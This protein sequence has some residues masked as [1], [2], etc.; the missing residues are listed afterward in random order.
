M[1]APVAVVLFL[2][3]LHAR[4]T[5]PAE[6]EKENKGQAD[7]SKRGLLP[8]LLGGSPG[9]GQSGIGGLLG[10]SPSHGY[11]G[12]PQSIGSGLVD[13]VTGLLPLG[14]QSPGGSLNDL[15]NGV[16]KYDQ[17]ATTA[18]P[19]PP[20][21]RGDAPWSQSERTYRQ[22]IT[23][24]GHTQGQR[25]IVLLVPPTGGNGQ[26]VWPRSPY[27]QLPRYG[28]SIC[29]VDNLSKSTGDA[30][31]TAE[32][33]AYAIIHLAAQSRQP[34]NVISYSQGGM[35]AQWAFTFWPS[36]RRLVTNFIALASPFHGT[37]AANVVC[38][39]LEVAGGCLPAVWQMMVNSR[40]Q[41]ALNARAPNSGARALVPTTSIYSYDDEIVLP[42][43]GGR[44][45]SALDGASNIAVQDVCGAQHF[46]DHFL[47]VGDHGAFGIALN[48]LMSGR[49]ANRANIDKSYCNQ[50]AGLGGQLG[51]LGNDLKY[52]F[53]TVV[54]NTGDRINSLLKTLTTLV[55]PELGIE[56]LD[57][58]L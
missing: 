29:W 38:P 24:L 47:I 40:F 35:D 43:V 51:S 12:G 22:Q 26:Q 28:F 9:R 57:R 58:F 21:A 39:L 32:F 33:I 37:Y 2:L 45:I 34:L 48:A 49:P 55:S 52:A 13:G 14:P 19:R 3:V 4:A 42:Q 15:L 54:G 46:A 18:G 50:L 7:L 8:S 44:P 23:C 1:I 25:G 27:A 6:L 41:Q 17:A 56:K 30:Q 20:T 31:L 5:E 16:P 36:T 11:G 10:G 53:A